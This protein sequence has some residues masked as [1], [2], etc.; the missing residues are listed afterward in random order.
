MMYGLRR[1]GVHRRGD[2]REISGSV[3]RNM[4]A[5]SAWKEKREEAAAMS[6]KKDAGHS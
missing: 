2:V 3:A 4:R 5:P 6:E 1:W